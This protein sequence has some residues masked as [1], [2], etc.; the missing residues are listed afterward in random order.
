MTTT[1][2]L[3]RHGHYE[4]N[5]NQVNSP[6]AFDPNNPLSSFGRG[7]IERLANRLRGKTIKTVITSE[8]KRA[9]ESGEII[10]TH[11]HI[12]IV[13]TPLLNEL[14]FFISPKEIMSF[15][16]NEENYIKAIKDVADASEKAIK[17]LEGVANDHPGETVAVVCHGNI[18][19]ALV[20]E[21]LKADVNSTIRLQVDEASL[22]ILEFD[23][24]DLF[25]LLRFND[26]CHLETND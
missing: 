5:Y 23:G 25:R 21:A 1:L 24:N 12:P 7:Q 17:F 14:G 4:G 13:S 19:R 26:T 15:E 9:Q 3:I 18:I 10:A 11:L 8:L 16:R 20:G 6:A 2:F 22:S